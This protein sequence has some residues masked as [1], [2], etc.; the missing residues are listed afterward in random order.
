MA[1]AIREALKSMLSRNY[2][3]VTLYQI[4]KIV[5][6]I[7]DLVREHIRD[8]LHH[9]QNGLPELIVNQ[10]LTFCQFGDARYYRHSDPNGGPIFGSCSMYKKEGNGRQCIEW[11]YTYIFGQPNRAQVQ[12]DFTSVE[13]FLIHLNNTA[14]TA[15]PR[16]VQQRIGVSRIEEEIQL[17]M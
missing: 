15:C 17:I 2:T 11:I 13:S 12:V 7:P 14:I 8:D 3:R 5:D 4:G 6:G 10:L 9:N 16:P 1:L